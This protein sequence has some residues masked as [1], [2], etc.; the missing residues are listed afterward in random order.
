[1]L[2]HESFEKED[3]AKLMN[4][5]FVNIKLDREERP[6]IDR[7]YM[8]YLQVRRV[9]HGDTRWSDYLLRLVEGEEDGLFRSVGARTHL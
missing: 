9:V 1:V 8:T 2:A 4:D 5:Y 3:T 6:D 7:V